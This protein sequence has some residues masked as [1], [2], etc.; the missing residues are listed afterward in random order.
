MD[1]NGVPDENGAYEIEVRYR[2]KDQV[3]G[4]GWLD[5]VEISVYADEENEPLYTLESQKY[6]PDA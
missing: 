2:E 4:A 5:T 3:T 6:R 1:E